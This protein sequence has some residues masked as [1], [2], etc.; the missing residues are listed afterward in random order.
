[1]VPLESATDS[2]NPPKPITPLA[3]PLPSEPDYFVDSESEAPCPAV[4]PCNSK[5]GPKTNR[6]SGPRGQGL[7]P[8]TGSW[9]KSHWVFSLIFTYTFPS[10]Y[11]HLL[12]CCPAYYTPQ[13]NLLLWGLDPNL[14]FVEAAIALWEWEEGSFLEKVSPFCSLHPPDL[15]YINF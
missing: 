5:N 15:F 2:D 10:A 3:S 14:S 8:T 11:F 12:F 4:L 9:G 6:H 7:P 13:I 1:M